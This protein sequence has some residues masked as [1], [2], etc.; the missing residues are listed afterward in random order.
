MDLLDAELADSVAA[1][2]AGVADQLVPAGRGR[3]LQ[4]QRVARL[5]VRLPGEDDFGIAPAPVPGQ[6]PRGT[7]AA[8]DAEHEGGQPAGGHAPASLGQPVLR[9]DVDGDCGLG[10]APVLP[11]GQCF[12]LVPAPAG[13]AD[14]AA[15]EDAEHEGAAPVEVARALG[16]DPGAGL[17]GD[18][19]Q[20]VRRGVDL[21]RGVRSDG[22]AV[23][24]RE[25]PDAAGGRAVAEDERGGLGPLAADHHAVGGDDHG[26]VEIIRAAR[27]HQGPA[28]APRHGLRAGLQGAAI[29]AVVIRLGAE[30]LDPRDFPHRRDAARDARMAPIRIDNAVGSHDVGRGEAI[31]L[32]R[33]DLVGR[34]PRRPGRVFTPTRQRQAQPNDN[35]AEHTSSRAA[36]SHSTRSSCRNLGQ[37]ALASGGREAPVLAANRRFAPRP[38]EN[39]PGVESV[40]DGQRGALLGRNRG[41]TAPARQPPLGAPRT[42]D[43][44]G[45]PTS[46]RS[47]CP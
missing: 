14:H 8:F 32:V 31:L 2:L 41:L 19:L 12:Q 20:P 4:L 26:P 1:P 44:A 46:R 23:A 43:R 16:D 21:D 6:L 27:E 34:L 5:E 29:V 37:P 18:P 28:P 25:E 40:A 45:N 15:A 7:P 13:A 9:V 35:R 33:L 39:S 47:R 42:A 24:G 36:E 30:L 22:L 38:S 11:L 17:Q 3:G 10:A